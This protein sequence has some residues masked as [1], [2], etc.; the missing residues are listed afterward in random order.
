[1]RNSVLD[2]TVFHKEQCIPKGFFWTKGSNKHKLCNVYNFNF[3]R[4]SAWK[5]MC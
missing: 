3:L 1:M 4:L 2:K 5:G